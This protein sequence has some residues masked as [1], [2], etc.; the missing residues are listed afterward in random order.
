MGRDAGGTLKEP[1]LVS[2]VDACS[3]ENVESWATQQ[4]RMMVQANIGRILRT[5]LTSST[6]LTVHSNAEWNGL[7]RTALF[8]NFRLCDASLSSRAGLIAILA[9]EFREFVLMQ[10]PNVAATKTCS[11]KN[12]KG[13][14]LR[15]RGEPAKK[16]MIDKNR[17][18]IAIPKP[19]SH[20]LLSSTHTTNVTAIRP[21]HERQKTK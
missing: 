17:L 9:I 6:S 3:T 20:P 10:Q 18:S 4:L 1:I 12:Q 15:Y 2:I 8:R 19:H 5:I 7:F 14:L 21:P 16:T 11:V 13:I